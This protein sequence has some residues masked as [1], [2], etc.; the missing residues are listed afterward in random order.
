MEVFLKGL[1]VVL[2]RLAV[3]ARCRAPLHFQVRRSQ[4]LHVAY[5][6]QERGEPLF[7]ILLCCLT[8]S[9]ERAERTIPALCPERVAL[10][11]VRIDQTEHPP[12]S[13]V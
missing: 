6:V 12:E 4:P 3:Y 8:Y 10:H 11:R 5:V 1:S 7:L 9:F 13:V 2:P